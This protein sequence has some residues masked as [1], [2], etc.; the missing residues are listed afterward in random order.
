MTD[1]WGISSYEAA[2]G[3]RVSYS[4]GTEE[5]NRDI[6]SAVERL[7]SLGVGEGDRV[8]VCSRLCEAAQWWPFT[9]A[10]MLLGAQVSLADSTPGDAMRIAMFCCE[11]EYRAVVGVNDA[12]IEGLRDIGAEPGE[13]FSPAGVV[14]ATPSAVSALGDASCEL[15]PMTTLGPTV[16]MA[17]GPSEPLRV[18]ADEWALGAHGGHITVSAVAARFEVFQQTRTAVRGTVVDSV[19]FHAET[20][21]EPMSSKELSR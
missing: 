20:V 19:T 18:T 8:L 12:V 16:A 11:L 21:P 17:E 13:V 6:A 15:R 2:T 4:A 7:A 3:E 5:V 10:P 9:I 14:G 1:V